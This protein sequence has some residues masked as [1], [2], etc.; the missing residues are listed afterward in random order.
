MSN[1]PL[2]GIICVCDNDAT[3]VER[4]LISASAQYYPNKKMFVLDN[5]SDDGSWEKINETSKNIIPYTQ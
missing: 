3:S 4:S 5:F 2:V 1:V